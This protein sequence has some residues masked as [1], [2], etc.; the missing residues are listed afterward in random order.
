M[1]EKRS[2]KDVISFKLWNL[3]QDIKIGVRKSVEWFNENKEF[4]ITVA[5]PMTIAVVGGVNKMARSI[6]RKMDLK[7]EQELKDL[8]VY[9]RS[10]GDYLTLRRKMSAK[11][12]VQFEARK[13]NG[14]PTAMILNEMGLLK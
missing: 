11:E 3:E 13:R 4:A 10:T 6:D 8:R 9:N 7:K 2:V 5:I 12:Q 14:E 1:Q